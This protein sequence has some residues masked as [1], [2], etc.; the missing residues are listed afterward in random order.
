MV[1]SGR[2]INNETLE[3]CTWT[4]FLHKM[5]DKEICARVPLTLTVEEDKSIAIIEFL[6]F[7]CAYGILMNHLMK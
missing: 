1:V 5:V 7:R 6:M 3:Y 2:I 4:W